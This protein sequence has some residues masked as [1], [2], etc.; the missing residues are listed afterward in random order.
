MALNKCIAKITIDG[1]KGSFSMPS[2]GRFNID[3]IINDYLK[4]S[5][6]YGITTK[7]NN[8]ISF[9]QTLSNSD[10]DNL[11]S[12]YDYGIGLGGGTANN[13]RIKNANFS[14]V[15][16]FKNDLKQHPITLYY[17]LN[18]ESRQTLDLGV[19]DMPLTYDEITNIFTDSDLL[20]TINV[21]YY[22]NFITTI[23]NLQINNDILKNELVSI[24]GRLTALENANTSIVDNNPSDIEGSEV[25]E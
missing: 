3:N 23:Q 2:A 4:T 22:R 11:T 9:P 10:F 20:P 8:Y 12:G 19:I 13:I 25:T 16:D 24:E 18:I 1:T 15:E 14:N 21:K 17:I 5:Q 6:S 7:C